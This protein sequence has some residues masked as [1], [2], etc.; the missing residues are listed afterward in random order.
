[1]LALQKRV[2]ELERVLDEKILEKRDPA[3][4]SD[5]AFVPDAQ[6]ALSQLSAWFEDYNENHAHKASQTKSPREFI[7]SYQQPAACPVG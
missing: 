3:R 2:R 7:R 4:G 1:V 5:E 6:T